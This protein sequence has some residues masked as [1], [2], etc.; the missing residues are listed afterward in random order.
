MAYRDR[1]GWTDRASRVDQGLGYISVEEAAHL[2]RSLLNDPGRLKALSA[3]AREVA[4][5]FSYERFK[6]RNE[7]IKELAGSKAKS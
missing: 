4:N 5:G 7:V 2:I 1:E 3:R 6:E